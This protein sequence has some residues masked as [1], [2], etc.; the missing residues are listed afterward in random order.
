LVGRLFCLVGWLIGGLDD[1]L[2]IGRGA[3][4]AAAAAA[5]RS[6]GGFDGRATGALPN[7]GAMGRVVLAWESGADGGQAKKVGAVS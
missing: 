3:A 2:Q 5:M 4:A 7:P 6:S 1:V